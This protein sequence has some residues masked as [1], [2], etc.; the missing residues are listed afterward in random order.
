MYWNRVYAVY[1][2]IFL[3]QMQQAFKFDFEN[4]GFG[5]CLTIFFP[6]IHIYFRNP[7]QSQAML[8]LYEMLCW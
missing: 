4:L 1:F 2:A 7:V 3:I 8:R 6:L 5:T